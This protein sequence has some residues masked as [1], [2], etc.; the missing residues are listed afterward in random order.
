MNLTTANEIGA[1]VLSLQEHIEN[2]ITMVTD[3]M[4][5]EVRS[6]GNMDWVQECAKEVK[7][8]RSDVRALAVIEAHAVSV[9]SNILSFPEDTARTSPSGLRILTIEVSQGMINQNLLTLTEAKARGVVHEG[10]RFTIRLPDE[11]SFSTELCSPGNKLRERGLIRK[12]YADAKIR[13][14]DKVVMTEVSQGSWTLSRLSSEEE[15]VRIRDEVEGLLK[16]LESD[17]VKPPTQPRES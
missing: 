1:S 4:G 2:I 12:F 3:R 5:D 9:L 16:E 17:S 15:H 8:L 13:E 7:R 10:E 14:G 11:T 6:D